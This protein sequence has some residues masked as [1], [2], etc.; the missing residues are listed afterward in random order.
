MTTA[1][2]PDLP[3]T[4]FLASMDAQL[5][6]LKLQLAAARK[7]LADV[8][9]DKGV[10]SITPDIQAAI[11][12][13]HH[14]RADCRKTDEEYVQFI[15]RD[16]HTKQRYNAAVA[17]QFVRIPHAGLQEL[18]TLDWLLVLRKSSRTGVEASELIEGLARAKG[19]G[20]VLQA[21]NDWRED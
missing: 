17:E 3:E 10:V 20:D 21:W 13:I 12:S 5:A 16:W 2:H 7:E 14:P 11:E 9:A 4:G 1:A 6:T 19:D 18:F 8:K 15:V